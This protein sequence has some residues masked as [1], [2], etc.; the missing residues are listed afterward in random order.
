MKHSRRLLSILLA[1][2]VAATCI[3]AGAAKPLAATE[4]V[5]A[6]DPDT[7]KRGT[8]VPEK[9]AEPSNDLPARWRNRPRQPGKARWTRRTPAGVTVHR[10][11]EFAKI[12]ER[13]LLLDLYVPEKAD[14]P[15]PLIVWVHGGGW[16]SGNK[17][18]CKATGLSGKGYVV[19]S[20]GYRL[21]G[22]APFPAQIHDCKAAVRWLRANA[23]TYKI[24]P[25][26]VGAWGSSAG[27]HLVA[28]LGTSGDV[29]ALEATELGNADQSSR[30]QAVCNFYGPGNIVTVLKQ[31]RVR[32]QK[33]SGAFYK[34][35]GG[36]IDEKQ[37]L[38]RLASPVT[39]ISKDDPPFLLVHGEKDRV[40]PY[41]QSVEFDKALKAG[42]VE[43]TFHTVKGA[44]H[45]FRDERVDKMVEEFFD[46]HLK[47]KAK[48]AAEKK[49]AEPKPAEVDAEPVRK[50]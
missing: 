45:G 35:F 36:P 26:H 25:K 37:D 14:G 19:A 5:Q 33:P 42:G 38:I 12:G 7:V 2:G 40:V 22:E 34:L 15:L 48:E 32:N 50:E 29:K 17:R 28:L 47:P 23:K 6:K 31:R 9:P 18:N 13:R 8:V 44:G 11:V 41:A 39:H 3:V 43:S 49:A 24:D 1:I 27:G 21:S 20:V 10:D 16:Q 30:V 46:K 4:A